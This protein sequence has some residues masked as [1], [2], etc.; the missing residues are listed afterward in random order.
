MGKR[1]LTVLLIED[2]PQYAHL[3]QH[4]LSSA[5]DGIEFQLNW[6]D[7]LAAGM[8]RL[9]RGGVDVIL[10][11]LGLPD[12]NGIE[13]YTQARARA[14]KTPILVLSSAD[15]ESLALQMIQEGAEDYLVKSSCD[16]EALIRAVRY[17]IVRRKS[18][19]GN[20][21]MPS[22]R[23]HVIGV[24][25]AKGGV[26]TTTIAC[27]L[28]SELRHQTDQEVLLADLDPDGG[29][30]S[31]LSGIECKFS[32]RDAV[33]NMQRLDLNCW[34]AIVAQAPDGLKVI[35]SAGLPGENRP[36]T[37]SLRDVLTFTQPLYRWTV[38][39][40]GRLNQESVALLGSVSEVFVV[41]TTAIP[42]LYNAKRVTEA[43]RTAEIEPER[44]RLLINRA[45]ERQQLS[46]RELNNMFGVPVYATI[47]NDT[48]E[49]YLACVQK[50]MPGKH[51]RVR[52]AIAGVARKLT[53]LPERSQKGKFT[54]LIALADR[55]RRPTERAA[56]SS[57]SV[58]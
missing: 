35:S 16:A 15:S 38:L 12:C 46:Q 23:S 49:L 34:E 47:P 2:S 32:I 25:G 22:M 10:L 30:V 21:Q 50:R 5:A 6:T 24:I 36:E 56:A 55:F 48:E 45:G 37:G 20:G 44:I 43:L 33:G 52:Q 41:T 39:D 26:G 8:S 57:G 53:G 3:V 4:W 40:L 17:A 51:S 13:T 54:S 28:A 29:N 9:E 31:F 19:I 27:T 58:T 1:I 18:Q 42:A 14:P 11:D 7:T